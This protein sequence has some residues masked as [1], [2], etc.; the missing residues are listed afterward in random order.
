MFCLS[1]IS[2][3]DKF[4]FLKL[5]GIIKM[6]KPNYAK[7]YLIFFVLFLGMNTLSAKE[8]LKLILI[9]HGEAWNNVKG[10]INSNPDHP[11]YIPVYL[12]GK[13]KEQCREIALKLNKMGV[14]R[15]NVAICLVSPLPRTQ[16]TARRLVREGVVSLDKLATEPR[17]I[18]SQM[19]DREGMSHSSFPYAQKHDHSNARSYGGE[20]DLDVRMR[21]AKL[22]NELKH[23]SYN[24]Y[25]ILVSHG[26]P[27]N[28][29][30]YVL[31][32]EKKR[33]KNAEALIY[34]VSRGNRSVAL[35]E[36]A[37]TSL[38]QGD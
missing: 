1:K 32:G 25:V 19:G 30:H 16:Q 28:E 35:S 37:H 5:M 4:C 23:E 36:M 34:S 31:T 3:P 21:M 13:G 8:D 2:F 33:F 26:T 27:C 7:L 38:G 14:G 12:T 20:T 11:N 22:L 6:T 10:I 17:I 9:R 24:G 29:L 15:H 18:E